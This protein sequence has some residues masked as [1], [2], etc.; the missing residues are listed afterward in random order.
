MMVDAAAVSVREPAFS[1]LDGRVALVTG[2]SRGIGRAVALDLAR[3]GAK[4]VVNY[5]CRE[6]DAAAVVG[7]IEALGGEATACQADVTNEGEVRRLATF[8]GRRHGRIDILVCNAGIVRDQLAA[9]MTLDQW[10]TVIQTHLRGS[11]LCIR[12]TL[13]VMMAQKSGNIVCLSSIA[14][15]H[16]GRGHINYV[17]AKG[18]VNAMTRSLAVELAPKGIR[19]NAVAPGVV[20]TDMTERVRNLAEDEIL[21]EIPLRRFGR[22]EDVAHAVRFLVSDEASYITGQ[23]LHVTGGF[24]L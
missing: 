3:A 12:E 1:T 8:A 20:V 11:F 7:E 17:A 15:D 18:G 16:A 13:P 23:V 2:A 9:A 21:K 22:P 4:V 19:V 24:G 5:L 10:D 6:A 14:A